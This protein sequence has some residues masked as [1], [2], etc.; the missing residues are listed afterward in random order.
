ME[1]EKIEDR[2][3]KRA[4]EKRKEEGFHFEIKNSTLNFDGRKKTGVNWK[5]NGMQWEKRKEKTRKRR[6]KMY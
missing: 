3:E 4:G 5:N 1:I 2:T 6:R